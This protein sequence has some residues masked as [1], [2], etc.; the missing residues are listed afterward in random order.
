MSF[1]LMVLV[2][3]F[4][5]RD[6]VR[7]NL[8]ANVQDAFFVAET[9]IKESLR[10]PNVT[11]FNASFVIERMINDGE[12]QERVHG[13]ML[14]ATRWFFEDKER[15]VDLSGL[16]GVI[17]G[18]FLDGA[19]V[20]LLSNDQAERQPWFVAAKNMDGRVATIAP[21][22]EPATRNV[23]TSF[24]RALYDANRNF[25]GVL[26]LDAYL[27]R[28]FE[29]VSSLRGT[30]GGYG[31]ILNENFE[32]IAHEDASLLGMSLRGLSRDY[33]DVAEKLAS[34]EDVFE[35]YIVDADGEKAI[36]FFR[37]IYNG[38]HIGMV[39]PLRGFYRDVRRTALILSVWSV[40]MMSILSFIL[41]R[42][43][44]AKMRLDE[45]NKSKSTFL[46]RMSHELRT[47][48]N[49]IIGMSE[50]ALREDGAS[51]M[52]EY[53]AS[54]RQAGHNLLSIINDIL[55]FSK[56]ESGNLPITPTPYRLAS[57]LNDVVNVVRVRLLEKPILFS[58]RV[59][60]GIR[61][62]L[63]GDEVRIRQALLNVLSNAVK[64]T[65]EGYIELAVDGEDLGDGEMLMTFKI[66]DSGI[67]IKEEN[68]ENLFGEFVK[69]DAERSR[70]V[71]GTGLGLTI[72]RRLCQAMGGDVTVESVYGKGSVFTVELVQKFADDEPLAVVENPGEKRV[73]LY[74][75][76][77]F[78]ASSVLATLRQ[79]GVR[80]EQALE[81]EEFFTKLKSDEFQFV[82]ASPRIMAQVAELAKS[83]NLE[84]R[85]VL[86]ADLGEIS[87]FQDIST[88]TMPTYAVP[89]A[90]ALNGAA[91]A[92][93]KTGAAR[94]FIAPEARVLVVDDNLINLKI[95]EGFLMPYRMRV[96]LC[97]SGAEALALA[98]ANRY[99]LIFMDHMMP[100]MDGV[101]TTI[102]LRAMK[103]CRNVPIVALTANAMP[104]MREM[105]L[106]KGMND[107]LPKPVDPAM[108]DRVL[109]QWIPKNKQTE[110]PKEQV[111]LL[112]ANA[113]TL[114]H[115]EDVDV[116]TAIKRLGGNAEA[117]LQV[118]RS[119]VTHTP[120]VLD[121]L[122]PDSP[123]E[124]EIAVHGIKGSSRSICANVIGDMAEELESAARAGDS[125]TIWAKN[126]A[127]IRAVEKVLA[128]LTVLLDSALEGREKKLAS[129]PDET[130][131]SVVFQA[132]RSYDVNAME[133]AISEMEQYA[134]ESKAEL[135]AWLRERLE[136]LEYDQIRE[137]LECELST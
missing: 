5:V 125:D 67:G 69:L 95:A 107:F 76:R 91:A 48:M 135:V 38:W 79:L 75:A 132:C 110:P 97:E 81:P 104:G 120:A 55:D 123:R 130:L 86:L 116:A 52:A 53:V 63:I 94:R 118:V 36:V 74:D 7:D 60:G 56:I 41:L 57:L 87:S 121:Q 137:R 82:F 108:L 96:E 133:Q 37:Q 73:L 17:R 68:L 80:V 131:L 32:I 27:T 39:A 90:N 70:S 62:N 29:Y 40:V 21:R 9:N 30:E 11:L 50:L 20:D 42:L 34:G 59:D 15:K 114:P 112:T 3:Y 31:M 45:D 136:A 119:Y 65:H 72:A 111:T 44:A 14:D 83:L 49:A 99:D 89:I 33:L 77:P 129:A 46:A 106:A 58:V 126:D 101:E 100:D 98:K 105:F 92:D 71:E 12:P 54:I 13:Y 26:A 35:K 23:V 25:L 1:F 88:L 84:A 19:R 113:P 93:K 124:Y 4:S 115:V 102:R 8:L 78:Y 117:Y 10:E 43:S 122:R 24:S 22:V 18:D 109:S 51:A 47:P 66:A 61:G 6:I 127:F 16:Y 85:L 128:N 64:Y 28:L 103:E 134:Y 2:G